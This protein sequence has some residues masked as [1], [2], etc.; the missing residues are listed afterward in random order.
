[1]PIPDDVREELGTVRQR[2]LE[3][4]VPLQPPEGE[5][6]D[7]CEGGKRSPGFSQEAPAFLDP[8]TVRRKARSSRLP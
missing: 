5:G 1:M 8:K 2:F 6:G 3:L 7:T 4:L